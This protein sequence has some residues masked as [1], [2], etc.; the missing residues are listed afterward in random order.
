MVDNTPIIT[1]HALRKMKQWG[2]S[3]KTV[4]DVFNNG[5]R[6]KASFG[7][8]WNAVRKYPSGEVGVNFDRNP[9][10]RYIIIS[11]WKRGRR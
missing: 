7:G 11:C 2:L 10:G 5:T 3:E 8:R 9:D 6:E 4:L 1:N